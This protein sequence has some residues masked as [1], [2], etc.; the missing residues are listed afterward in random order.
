PLLPEDARVSFHALLKRLM[1]GPT[2]A[3]DEDASAFNLREA[4]ADGYHK[5]MK[6]ACGNRRLF[7]M[8]NGW[9][10]LG[11]RIAQIGDI[12]AVF[13]AFT[14]PVMLRPLSSNGHHKICDDVYVSH[15]INGDWL[16]TQKKQGKTEDVFYL[17]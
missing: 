9:I 15:V 14:R 10:G 13:W 7:I 6:V 8:D 16:V 1:V 3:Q 17:H 5:A 2:H 11:P 4:K 12:I